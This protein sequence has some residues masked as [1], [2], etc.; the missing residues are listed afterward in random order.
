M[1]AFC[2]FYL[3][4]LLVNCW[5]SLSLGI[6]NSCDV[7]VGVRGRLALISLLALKGLLRVARLNGFVLDY[8]LKCLLHC[9]KKATL[10]PGLRI[11]EL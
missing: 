4:V 2:D 1:K 9:H 7:N 11:L 10:K 5:L 3:L 6:G 8:G